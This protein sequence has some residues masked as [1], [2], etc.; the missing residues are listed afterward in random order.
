MIANAITFVPLILIMDRFNGAVL[1]MLIS[2]P[3]GVLFIYIFG[4]ALSRFPGEGIPEIFDRY[5]PK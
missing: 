4:K 1:S 5:Y 3:V 2:V